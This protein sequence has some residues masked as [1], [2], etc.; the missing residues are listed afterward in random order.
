MLSLT[1][2]MMFW[3]NLAPRISGTPDVLPVT[4][5]KE[6]GK[7]IQGL[8]PD[9]LTIF[10]FPPLADSNRSSAVNFIEECKCVIF[11]MKK[12]NPQR[13]SAFSILEETQPAVEVLKANLLELGCCAPFEV[14]RTSVET[15]P[16]TELYGTFAGWS[17]SF[18]AK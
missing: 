15:A 3:R 12:Y 16:E 2:Y 1:D 17:I 8:A 4:I 10:V 6:M 14:V 13:V 5:D 7:K 11:L 18:V 9:S